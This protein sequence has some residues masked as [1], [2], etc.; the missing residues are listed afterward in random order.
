MVQSTSAIGFAELER[1]ALTLE[2]ELRLDEAR[3]AFDAALRLSPGSQ[4][5]AE[6]RAR[7]ALALREEAAALR[8]ESN[9]AFWDALFGL[10]L[11]DDR[12]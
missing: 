10:D 1:R 6:G 9:D 2:A 11:G 4:S 8:A 7:I 12:H 5:A 3:D